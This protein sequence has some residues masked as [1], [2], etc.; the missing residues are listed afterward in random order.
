MVGTG[1][2]SGASLTANPGSV[3]FG[4]V[5]VGSNGQQTI[6]LTN[7]G[8]TGVTIS[9]I[10]ASGTGFSVAGLSTP[11]PLAA[12]QST[13]FTTKFAPSSAGSA[14]GNIQITSDASNPT[15]SV[16]L[17][18]T[19]VQGNLT[20]NP[21][22]INF[23][24]L[25]VG[26]SGSVSVTL[27]NSGTGSVAIS[28]GNASGTGFSMSGL[29][30]PATLNAGQSTSFTAK[31]SPTAS[32][33]A[34]GSISIASNAPGSPLVIALSG[35]G[36]ASQPQLTISPA[37]AAFGSVAVGSSG[38]QTITLTNAGTVE[39]DGDASDAFRQR[40]QRERREYADV[41][42]C[43][44]QRVFFCHLHPNHRRSRSGQHFDRQQCSGLTGS[45]RLER[46][47]H[48]TAAGGYAHERSVRQRDDGDQQFAKLHSDE[49]RQREPNDFIGDDHGSR[50]QHLGNNSAGDHRGGQLCDVQRS[51]WTKL[52]GKRH[53]ID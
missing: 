19:G 26:A 49:W 34:T 44:Q 40:I 39:I 47:R 1:V 51:L 24:S 46:D 3:A 28:T 33:S 53:W 17:S 31:F 45:D 6:N 23:G 5:A 16:A 27:T 35:S 7:A 15:V 4:N 2:A 36:T 18:G 13:S 52:R 12:G 8:S 41:H 37:S 48:A 14:V 29:T 10:S 20:A 43:R 25:L 22:S 50:V 21:A 9:A 11:M 30:T 42:Q 38:T 32:G